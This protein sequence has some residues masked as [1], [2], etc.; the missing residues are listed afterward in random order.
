MVITAVNGIPLKGMDLKTMQ[1]IFGAANGD[2][3]LSVVGQ[4]DMHIKKAP[5]PAG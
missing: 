3:V 4:A 5:I 1:A 2:I